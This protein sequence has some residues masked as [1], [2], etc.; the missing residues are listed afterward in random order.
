MS[1]SFFSRWLYGLAFWFAVGMT[2]TVCAGY[3]NDFTYTDT[4][5]AVFAYFGL[6]RGTP[7]YEAWIEASPAYRNAPEAKKPTMLRQEALRLGKGFGTIETSAI[8]LKIKTDIVVQLASGPSGAQLSFKFLNSAN[9]EIPY[10]P[11]PYGGDWIAL[12][13][14]DLGNFT[15]VQ[16][17]KAEED[18]A[19]KYLKEGEIYPARML[20]QARPV[21]ADPA[22]VYVGGD[23]Q[24]LMLGK[25]GRIAFLLP[26]ASG[27][28]EITLWSYMA[29]DFLTETEKMLFPLLEKK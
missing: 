17:T 28:D 14:N 16:L 24:W 27:E 2:S 8:T 6:A 7:D 1:R 29:P 3:T 26:T 21:S 9:E 19:R 11:Y 22:P 13:L 18:A 5:K 12:I 23:R 10:F 25:I 15:T 20:L 4:E